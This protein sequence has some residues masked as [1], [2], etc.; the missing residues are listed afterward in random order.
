MNEPAPA[1]TPVVAIA[2]LTS[3]LAAA[4]CVAGYL[5]YTSHG[6]SEEI[7]ALQSQVEDS[8][9]QIA[10]LQP[11]AEKARQLPIVTRI[12]RHAANSGYNMIIINRSRDSLRLNIA[13]TAGGKVKNFIPVVD[14]NHFFMVRSLAPGDSVAIGADGYDTTTVPIESG[15]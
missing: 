9:K 2:V 1:K 14:G 11:L 6:Q 10:Q 15:P 7:S 4:V 8:E 5:A 3:L 13:V 12:N